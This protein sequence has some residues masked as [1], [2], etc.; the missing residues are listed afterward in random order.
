MKTISLARLAATLAGLGL[1]ALPLAC[2]AAAGSDAQKEL[3][4]V[5]A[6]RAFGFKLLSELAKEKPDTNLFISPA[7]VAFALG[8]ARNGARGT[9]EEEMAEALEMPGVGLTN[10][11]A[12]NRQL[13]G[14]L[15]AM[16]PNVT[17][18]SANSLWADKGTEFNADFL[19]RTRESFQAEVT[20]LDLTD[21]ATPATINAWADKKTHGRVRNVIDGPL[22]KADRLVLLN[23]TYFKGTWTHR[24]NKALTKDRP[25]H[26][27]NG[28]ER[29]H[30]FMAQMGTYRYLAGKAF[31]AVSLPYGKGRA[32]MY[33][34]L[35]AQESSL[36]AFIESLTEANWKRWL[37]N[38]KDMEGSVALPKF[39]LETRTDLKE[40]LKALGVKAAFGDE[41]TDLFGMATEPLFISRFFQ[42]AFVEVNEE[43]TE[44]AAVTGGAVTL[45]ARPPGPFFTL[46]VDRPFFFV[47]R[48]NLTGTVLFLGAIA[49]PG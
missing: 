16:D 20:A 33:V 10:F 19:R 25:F 5:T 34:F 43:G 31:Q 46:I 27:L 35:P 4:V 3:R 23:A 21:P 44:A 48:D 30:P 29:Q 6:Y 15:R 22:D 37:A 45:G 7:S 17:L 39:K 26:L 18:E 1:L 47:I 11:N 14:L 41:K 38:F 32:S 36:K 40:P 28:T 12:A 2:G 42:R 24:F 9:T 49:D 8:M 13:L